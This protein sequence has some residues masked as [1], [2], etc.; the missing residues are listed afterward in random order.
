MLQTFLQPSGIVTDALRL[1]FSLI[2][3]IVYGLLAF[4]TA[5]FYNVANAQ[6]I[7]GTIMHDFFSRIQLIL[8]IIVMF[9][10]AMSLFTG[11]INPD[12]LSDKKN[13]F[14]GIIK[15]VIIVL[16]M[17][18]LIVPLDIPGVDIDDISTNGQVSWNA[19]M[20]A[21]GI[22]FGTLF[23]LQSRLLK[24]NVLAKL[25]LGESGSKGTTTDS[26]LKSGATLSRIIFKC[27]FMINMDDEGEYL[28][29]A[30]TTI[31]G[32]EE[33]KLEKA[34]DIYEND[35]STPGMLLTLV[36]LTCDDSGG[37]FH[38]PIIGTLF[39]LVGAL[40][41]LFSGGSFYAFNYMFL[42]S[43][44]VGVFCVFVMVSYTIDAAIRLF[45][46]MILYMISPVPI[47]SYIDPKTEK[48]F[49]NW[50]K[51]VLSTY[52]DLFIRLIIIY[53]II[54]L[55]GEI[56]EMIMNGQADL[57]GLESDGVA[58]GLVGVFSRVF[59]YLG[60][61]MFARKAPKFITDT[62]GLQNTKGLF[63]GLS[64]LVGGI[65]SGVQ[66]YKASQDAIRTNTSGKEVER[67][68]RLKSLGAG[69]FN[70]IDSAGNAYSD[71]EGAKDHKF[72]STMD[73]INQ[74]NAIRRANA[75]EG[76]TFGK[77][78][79]AQAQQDLTG[80]S[81][82]DML[83]RAKDQHERD[84]KAAEARL[85]QQKAALKPTKQKYSDIDKALSAAKDTVKAKGA[86][87]SIRGF[88]YKD[89]K[90]NE[91][92][93]DYDGNLNLLKQFNETGM[94]SADGL[95]RIKDANGKELAALKADDFGSFY[96]QAI[97]ASA[98]SYIKG[99]AKF[100]NGGAMSNAEHSS[101]FAAAVAAAGGN[102]L[103]VMKDKKT[104]FGNEV[105]TQESAIAA[106]ESDISELRTGEV[107]ING[108]TMKDANNNPLTWGGID[109]EISREEKILRGSDGRRG[110]KQ[111]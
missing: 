61:F 89:A 26:N 8:G 43:T 90:G 79:M 55:I 24:Q 12:S 88:K 98:E 81:R 68:S 92:T 45:K 1:I 53:I 101:L 30:D 104:T 69:L 46:L 76:V 41:D 62:L 22:A 78:L 47:I 57:L 50:V 111:A 29:P 72:R 52:L 70:G 86:K 84:V 106:A 37:S 85:E 33:T 103:S 13:G 36:N 31:T 82:Y 10:V 7:S 94:R 11:I 93:L 25:I 99:T 91:H 40:F 74:Q 39:G 51:T 3:G 83:K 32:L 42:I 4:V 65:S 97:D 18:V 44:I 105:K 110:G 67:T 77:S 75:A 59:I 109:A 87:T 73:R 56:D 102:D 9:K 15:R 100:S 107:E 23:E 96:A 14:G 60:L 20:N 54:F 66:G 5:V 27:F 2:D 63:S 6:L 80:G 38:I 108:V 21:S 71:Y 35:D 16:I 49:Q 95:Y 64:S 28:C 34:Y 48:N 17:L 58:G 19:R